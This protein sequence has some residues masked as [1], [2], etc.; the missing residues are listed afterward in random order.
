MILRACFGSFAVIVPILCKWPAM[1]LGLLSATSMVAVGL[2]KRES[3]SIREAPE[4]RAKVPA[5][6]RSRSCETAGQG[7]LGG[8]TRRFM[9]SRPNRPV[10]RS[11]L[12]ALPP[13]CDDGGHNR[14]SD[15]QSDQTKGLQ[16]AED[17]QQN[18]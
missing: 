17:A 15:K 14:W 1:C 4:R 13:D 5:G 16:A 10:G 8:P 9:S 2:H 12:G 6:R 3:V 11:R 18:P 7:P